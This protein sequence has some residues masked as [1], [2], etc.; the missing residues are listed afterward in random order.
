[1]T[2]MMK[3]RYKTAKMGIELGGPAGQIDLLAPGALSRLQDQFHDRP[4]H[5]FISLGRGFEVAVSTP[6][7]AQE[8]KIHLQRLDFRAMQSFIVDSGNLCFE[9]V[10]R[11]SS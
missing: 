4:L 1:M 9:I 3:N 8:P 5:D 11:Y 7:V 10:H 2:F 6:L